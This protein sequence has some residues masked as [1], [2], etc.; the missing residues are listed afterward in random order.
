MSYCYIYFKDCI[1][2]IVDFRDEMLRMDMKE[3]KIDKVIKKVYL[4]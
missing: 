3:K 4:F 1:T 2:N